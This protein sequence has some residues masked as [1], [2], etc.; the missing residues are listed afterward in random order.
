M[1]CKESIKEYCKSLRLDLVGF[2]KCRIFHELIPE[3]TERQN[4]NRQNEFEGKNINKRVD[5]F[6]YMKEGKTIISIAFPY[7]FNLDHK[8]DIYFSKYTQGRDYHIVV[9]E[10]LQKICNFI[11]SKGY[12]AEYFVD[13]NDL[14]ERYIAYL[15]GIGFIGKNNMLIT[16]KYGSYIF[17][18]EII[19]DIEMDE[20][21]PIECKCKDCNRCIKVCPT[22]SLSSKNPNICLSYITQK[23]HIEDEWMTKL[24]GRMF[25]CDTCQR[26]CPYNNNVITSDIEEFKPFN[27]MEN[28]NL[29]ELIYINNKDFKEKYKLTSCG[30]RGKSILQRN[31][32]INCI[33]LN[34]NVKVEGKNIKSPYVLDYYHR[35]LKK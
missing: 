12:R 28:L 2:T 7:L 15:C 16:E 9:N 27:Y 13:S 22:D 11:K 10:Y 31:A 19:T 24:K 34:N 25:G 26:I 32:L 29:E 33:T 23:K 8:C 6:Q 1:D 5:P 17:L 3:F 35:L 14:P 30:W 20:D 21:E 4:K 18:G